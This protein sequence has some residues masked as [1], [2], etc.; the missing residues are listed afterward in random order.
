MCDLCRT[1]D[2][3]A[4]AVALGDNRAKKLSE[5]LQQVYMRRS[6]EDTLSSFLPKKDERIVFCE[7]SDLQKELYEFILEQPDFVVLRQ[8]NAPCDCG[9]NKKVRAS[10]VLLKI[11]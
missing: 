9:V 3:T 2:A 8:K 6:K 10:I 1:K 7:L 11:I 5:K 4:E